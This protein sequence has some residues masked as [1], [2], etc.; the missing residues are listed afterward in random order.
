[1]SGNERTMWRE[2]E[3]SER[4]RVARNITRTRERA[5][6]NEQPT[7]GNLGLYYANIPQQ[8]TQLNKLGVTPGE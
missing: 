4:K 8:Q 7:S 1:M 3:R 6:E 2:N 5:G